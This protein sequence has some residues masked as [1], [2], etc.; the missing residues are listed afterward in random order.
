MQKLIRAVIAQFYRCFIKRFPVD[1]NMWRPF[2]IGFSS[3]KFSGSNGINGF[4]QIIVFV[5]NAGTHLRKIGLPN[6]IGYAPL[7]VKNDA[8]LRIKIQFS[9]LPVRVFDVL[10]F[11]TVVFD[12]TGFDTM[13]IGID[14]KIKIVF[15]I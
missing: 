14:T 1:G 8:M 3:I 12:F 5:K 11:S 2:V 6:P 7:F 13:P 10:R 15:T 9:R 4:T